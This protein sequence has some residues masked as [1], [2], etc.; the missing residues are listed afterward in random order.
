MIDRYG[1]AALMVG[2]AIAL[3]RAVLSDRLVLCPFRGLTGLP[4]PT[5]GFTRSWQAAGHL[6]LH[7]S[8]AY[9]PLGVASMVAAAGIALGGR[10]GTARVVDRRE[11]QLSAGAV[12][13]AAWLWRLKRARQL[14]LA[15]V[16][17]A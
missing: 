3:P 8:V 10:E 9:H 4:C 17:P 7:D 5:C 12:W 2:A 15:A 13:L 6:R 11:V 14:R 1:V 16:R